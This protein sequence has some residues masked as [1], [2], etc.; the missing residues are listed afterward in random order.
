[1]GRTQREV[2]RASERIKG[3]GEELK[4]S[5]KKGVGQALDDERLEA[6]GHLDKARGKVRRKLNE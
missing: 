1:M 5:V 4:G 6:E 2:G 3:A